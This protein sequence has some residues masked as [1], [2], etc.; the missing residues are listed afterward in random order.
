[1]ETKIY[2]AGV[3]YNYDKDS[4]NYQ[5][6]KGGFVYTFMQAIDARDA[7]DMLLQALKGKKL[8][9]LEVEFIS[10]YDGEMEWETEEETNRYISLYNEALESGNVIFDDFYAYES[11]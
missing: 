10:I 2:W 4:G 11:E 7:L 3:E 8:A 6:L 9:P 1:M 5:E